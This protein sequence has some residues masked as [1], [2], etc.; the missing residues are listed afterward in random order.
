MDGSSGEEKDEYEEEVPRKHHRGAVEE[1]R[2]FWETEMRTEIPKFH[3]SLQPEEFLD[4]L[5][6]VKEILEFKGV[7]TNKHVPLVEMRHGGNS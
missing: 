6:T 5:P 2:Q 7:P 3:S 1:D 4:W